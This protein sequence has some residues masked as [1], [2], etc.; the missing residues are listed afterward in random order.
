MALFEWLVMC[1][2]GGMLL[3]SYVF[4]KLLTYLLHGAESILINQQVSS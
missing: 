4:L 3:L 2:K 1:D